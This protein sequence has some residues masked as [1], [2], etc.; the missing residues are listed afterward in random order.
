MSLTQQSAS[1]AL[2]EIEEKKPALGNGGFHLTHGLINRLVLC[3]DVLIVILG[4]WLVPFGSVLDGW[5]RLVLGLIEAYFYVTVMQFHVAYRVEYYTR[6]FWPLGYIAIGLFVAWFAGTCLLMVY[7]HSSYHY[8]HHLVPVHLMLFGLLALARQLE[9]RLVDG[10]NARSLLR[11]NVV[12]IGSGDH[13]VSVIRYLNEPAQAEYHRVVGVFNE[14]MELQGR[15]EHRRS[16]EA[17]VQ[18]N[19]VDMVVIGLP[20]SRAAEISELVEKVQWIS[21]DV[22]IPFPFAE[23]GVQPHVARIIRL[24]SIAGLLV[25]YR[26]FKGSEGLL[27]IAEDYV[28]AA[29]ALLITSPVLLLA[30]IA[31]RLDSPGPALFRQARTGFNNQPFS[32]FK[33]RTMTVDPD[34]DGS[35]GTRGRD[36]PRITRV[37]KFLRK[38]SIDELPQLLNVLRGEMSVVGPRPY[39]PNMLVGDEPITRA[40]RQYA[41]RHRI[42]PGI[43]GWAQS[44]GMRGGALRDREK[45]RRSVEMDMYYITHWSIWFDLRVMARTLL[46]GM[47]GK[48]VF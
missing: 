7:A 4:L 21:A 46:I 40:V 24:G 47:M 33:F 37:G 8:G 41:A 15:G 10:V 42:K 31:I 39:V 13:A 5:Q 18:D 28:V 6:L 19:L 43:T 26:P 1:E 14:R 3:T 34:D 16:L 27:K 23:A 17:L 22:V 38:T 11:R 9:H 36:D 32:I 48:D 20:L 2:P 35:E 45:A 44:K 30:A 12:V 29:L 25:A